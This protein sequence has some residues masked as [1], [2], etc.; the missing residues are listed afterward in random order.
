[1]AARMM[2]DY[3]Q[4]YGL[5]KERDFAL[6]LDIINKKVKHYIA[7]STAVAKNSEQTDIVSSTKSMQDIAKLVTETISEI[8]DTYKYIL[9]IY[10]GSMENLVSYVTGEF[11]VIQHAV[12][13]M[14]KHKISQLRNKPIP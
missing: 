5:N 3:L 2:A 7:I 8:S 4:K 14:N 10:L 1:M 9:Y 6:L 11:N 12:I 13:E